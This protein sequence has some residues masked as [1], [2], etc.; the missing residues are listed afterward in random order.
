[1]CTNL[2]EYANLDLDRSRFFQKEGG[3]RSMYIY[4]LE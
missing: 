4:V 3:L 2:F 1:M